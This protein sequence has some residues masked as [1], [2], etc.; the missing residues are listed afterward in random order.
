MKV[1]RSQCWRL[2]PALLLVLTAACLPAEEQVRAPVGEALRASLSGLEPS[3]IAPYGPASLA[4]CGESTCIGGSG[5]PAGWIIAYA[6]DPT[7]TY[8]LRIGGSA[9]EGAATLR[10]SVGG[11]GP[12][13]GP[14]PN[15]E[16]EVTVFDAEAV[17]V[18]LYGGSQFRYRLDE[19]N[20]SECPSCPT[21][22]DLRA[23]I[24]AERPDLGELLDRERLM[25]AERLLD[26]AANAAD[27]ALDS[28]AL[29]E[30]RNA[31]HMP[32]AQLYYEFLA[33]DR[34]PG[35]C[36]AA[37]VF[38]DRVA[39]VFGLDTFTINFGDLRGDLTH[40]SVVLAEPGENG[41]GYR[42]HLFDPTFNTTFRHLATGDYATVFEMA[43]SF[44]AGRMSEIYASSA[45]LGDRS[46]FT[47]RTE[48]WNNPYSQGAAD[49][50]V[51]LG[52]SPRGESVFGLVP[53]SRP[54][55]S[56]AEYLRL[57]RDPLTKYGYG[58]DLGGF[59]R[60]FEN[61]VFGVGASRDPQAARQFVAELERRGIPYGATANTK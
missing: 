17:E 7:R 27:F 34:A 38:F 22:A 35:Y 1:R 51:I 60:L 3:A 23:L 49:L 45:P 33:T 61:R 5:A 42:F 57:H 24:L 47:F 28:E 59:V 12:T 44:D 15:R 2:A 40:V 36:S 13:Y 4:A 46:W 20:L 18:L 6:L 55:Y 8:R 50:N 16:T 52:I 39:R 54:G 48:R 11:R 37:A 10:L 41:E 31:Q 29:A 43:D 53:L 30:I 56:L 9:V 14:A 26:W 25:A 32:A 19:V 58:A 21:D